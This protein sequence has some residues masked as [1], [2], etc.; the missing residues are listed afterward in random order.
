[1]KK[2]ITNRY[3]NDFLILLV[4]EY[5]YRLWF[6]FPNITSKE[7]DTWWSVLDSVDPYFMTPELLLGD[8]YQVENDDEFE[9]FT[10]LQDTCQLYTVHIHTDDD[11]VLTKP[12]GTK[13]YHKGYESSSNIL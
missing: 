3:K 8:L 10:T 13:I 9:L 12:N 7:L 1:M 4:E 11:S 5:G 2:E 6:W